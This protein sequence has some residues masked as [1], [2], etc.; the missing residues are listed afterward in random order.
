M[1]SKTFIFETWLFLYHLVA[2]MYIV[3]IKQLHFIL[4]NSKANM[5]FKLRV[6]VKR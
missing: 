4:R 5:F 3:H 1:Q 6:T 2:T